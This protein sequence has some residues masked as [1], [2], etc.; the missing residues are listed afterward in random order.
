MIILSLIVWASLT[1]TK[2]FE[3]IGC[4]KDTFDR[5]LRH[6]PQDYGFD[7]DSCSNACSDYQYFALKND[8]WFVVYSI[9]SNIE[10][11]IY[12]HIAKVL[13]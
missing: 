6:G 7:V 5:A 10:P 12:P 9:Y 11:I 8:G 4:F 2:A 13:V 1:T 3:H